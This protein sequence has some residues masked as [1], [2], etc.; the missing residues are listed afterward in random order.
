MNEHSFIRSIHRKLP[1]DVYA[2]KINDN[3]QGGVADAYYSKVAGNDMW[4][5]YK[6]L[7]SLPKRMSTTVRLGLSEL[8]IEWLAARLLDGRTVAVIVGSPAGHLIL[9][10]GEWENPISTEFFTRNA[11]ETSAVVAYILSILSKTLN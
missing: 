1:A 8:Q 7:K 3:F 4:I 9:R 2:W 6:F 11:V 5:E 10:E